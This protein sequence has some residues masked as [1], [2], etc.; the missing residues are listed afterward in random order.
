MTWA[1][2]DHFRGRTRGWGLLG[3]VPRVSDTPAA[4][5]PPPVDPWAG[6]DGHTFTMGMASIPART[7]APVP[8]PEPEPRVVYAERPRRRR[9]P[10]V[11]GVLTALSLGCCGVLAAVTAPMREQW[12]VRA[13]IGGEVAGLVRD[14]SA[15]VR[16]AAN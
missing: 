4:P 3:T 8:P 12:P 1:F 13:Q 7:A 2:V 16:N 9:W 15:E 5:P 10:W 11:L 14:D 6:R